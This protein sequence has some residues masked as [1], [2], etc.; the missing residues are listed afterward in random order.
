MKIREFN[1]NP[2]DKIPL[3]E[4]AE[5]LVNELKDLGGMEPAIFAARFKG[6]GLVSQ[7]YRDL[8]AARMRQSRLFRRFHRRIQHPR[9]PVLPAMVMIPTV[10]DT[11][12]W[13]E[14]L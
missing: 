4:P 5:I 3:A 14:R 9:S 13:K 6:Q 12:P 11:R 2:M 10:I 7:A 1:R 8:L